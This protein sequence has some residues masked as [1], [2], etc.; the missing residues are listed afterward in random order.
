MKC[1]LRSRIRI[2]G[3]DQ[4]MGDLAAKCH[5]S[6]FAWIFPPIGITEQVRVMLLT[7]E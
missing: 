4:H 7:A 1:G 3:D 2:F 6:N 5:N